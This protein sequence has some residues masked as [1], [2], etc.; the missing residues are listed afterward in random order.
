MSDEE[1]IKKLHR[2]KT[3]KEAADKGKFTE[4]LGKVPVPARTE[5]QERDYLARL[6]RFR[7][8]FNKHK[9]KSGKA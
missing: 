1:E 6:E 3:V 9:E 2:T 7:L 4:F 8:A 5:E